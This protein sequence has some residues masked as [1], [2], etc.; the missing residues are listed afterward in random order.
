MVDIYIVKLLYLHTIA[1]GIDL[2]SR[3]VEEAKHFDV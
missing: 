3:H 1:D 2:D